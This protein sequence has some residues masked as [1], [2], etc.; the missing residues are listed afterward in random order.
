VCLLL[1]WFFSSVL[2]SLSFLVFQITLK[3]LGFLF[4]HSRFLVHVHVKET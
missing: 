3:C 1:F 4:R 2:A